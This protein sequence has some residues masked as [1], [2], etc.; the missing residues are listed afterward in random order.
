MTEHIERGFVTG[1]SGVDEAQAA[2][3]GLSIGVSGMGRQLVTGL[4]ALEPPILQLLE[5]RWPQKIFP[6]FA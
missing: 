2:V 6:F 5:A 4:H 3:L 1:E